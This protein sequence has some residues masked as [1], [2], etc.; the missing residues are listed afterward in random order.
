MGRF[1]I[2]FYFIAA[3]KLDERLALIHFHM[4]T[5]RNYGNFNVVRYDII[6]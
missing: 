5:K 4:I 3:L 6:M 1:N 2:G